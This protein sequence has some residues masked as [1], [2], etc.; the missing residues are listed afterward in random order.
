VMQ[1][2]AFLA[3]LV[4]LSMVGGNCT[5]TPAEAAGAVLMA[6]PIAFLGG[7]F[8][9]LML[10]SMWTPLLGNA[11][12]AMGPLGVTLG[13]LLGLAALGGSSEKGA[14]EWFDAAVVVYGTSYLSVLFIVWR[15]WLRARPETAFTKAPI[16]VM[17][18]MLLPAPFLLLGDVSKGAAEPFIS[19]WIFPGMFGYATL[20]ISL[21]VF[22]EALV[23]RLL[24]KGP[25]PASDGSAAPTAPAEPAEQPSEPRV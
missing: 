8:A 11:P 5:P 7:I 6:A 12:M 24:Y 22:G 25:A 3:A 17:A 2:R 20:P 16:A 4:L 15:V 13:V 23:R 1:K 19:M 21:I 9:L 18:V 10:R 14:F